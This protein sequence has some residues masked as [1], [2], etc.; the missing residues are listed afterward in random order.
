MTLDKLNKAATLSGR[1]FDVCDLTKALE[2]RTKL[3][4]RDISGKPSDEDRSVI[5][6]CELVHGLRL[7]IVSDWGVP[8]VVHATNGRSSR[9]GWTWHTHSSWPSTTSLVLWCGCRDTHRTI[10]A[11]D[12]LHLLQCPLLVALVGEANKTISARHSADWIGHDLSGL[13]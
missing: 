13:A 6:V 4:L 2:E 8:H 1:N 12:S 11:V 7:T 3:V 9:A 5:R 10:A